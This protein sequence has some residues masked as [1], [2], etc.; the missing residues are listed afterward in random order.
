MS[1]NETEST[2]VADG[3]IRQIP[4][5]ITVTPAAAV[6]E[7]RDALLAAI[8]AE[9]QHVADKSAGQ[10]SAALM[11]LA[12]TYA[13]TAVST[14]SQA[15]NAAKAVM[16]TSEAVGLWGAQDYARTLASTTA[17]DQD[18]PGTDEHPPTAV[19]ASEGIRQIPPQITA[20]QAPAVTDTRDALLR[21]IGSKAQHVAEKSAGQASAVLLELARAY[22]LVIA[23]STPVIDA[24][25]PDASAGLAPAQE[26]A[27]G[28]RRRDLELTCQLVVGEPDSDANYRAPLKITAKTTDFAPG[29]Y[30]GT[31]TMTFDAVPRA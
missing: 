13:M 10:A 4:A 17:S 5:Q 7:A 18:R 8:G 6:A 26:G 27:S 20:T 3:E 2:P 28:I 24:A 14:Y 21:A 31:V 30:T 12:R 23:G 15:A 11:E 16:W 29:D 19:G 25:S 1:S 9:A 22:A